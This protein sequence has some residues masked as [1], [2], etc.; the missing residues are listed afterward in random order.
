MIKILK[1]V[2]EMKEYRG[3]LTATTVG[4]VPTMGS[5]HEGHFELIRNSKKNNAVTIVS[6]FVN[7]AQ[8]NNRNDFETYP[9]RLESDIAS[10][11]DLGVDAVITPTEKDVYPKGYNFKLTESIDSVD[12]C[13][14]A[15]PGHFD[16]VL[17]VL[18]KLFNLVKPSDVYMGIK[19]YQQFKLVKNMAEDLFL[20]LTVH[21]VETV[22]EESGLALSSRNINL[23]SEQKKTAEEYANIFAQD[24]P[25]P[26]IK[27]QLEQLNLKIDYLVEKWGRKFVAVFIGNVRLIDNRALPFSDISSSLE[28]DDAST[29]VNAEETRAFNALEIAKIKNNHL[30]D[31]KKILF[32]MSGSIACYKACDVISKLVQQGHQVKVAVTPDVFHF[33]GQGTIEGLIGSSVYVDM[34]QSGEMMSHIHLN[35]WCDITIL[36][37][38]SANTLT[39]I[40]LG[41]SDNLVT[42]LALS[43]D[44][45]KPYLVFP[46]MNTRML[47][48]Q[49]TQTSLEKLKARGQKII[50]GESGSLACGHVG[51][52]RLAEPSVILDII[53]DELRSKPKST[54]QRQ[55]VN[56]SAVERKK[57]LVTAGGTSEAIDPVRIVT[58]TSTGETGLQIC[59]Y[60]LKDYDVYLLASSAMKARI[61]DKELPHVDYFKSYND[62]EEKLE[63]LL[64]SNEFTAVIHLAAVSD[65]S[66]SVIHFSDKSIT[67]PTDEKIPSTEDFTVEF[68][69]NKK[70]ISEIRRH[71]LNKNIKVI[72]FKLLRTDD[73]S[74]IQREIEKI[75]K[76]SDCVVVNSLENIS[77][78]QHVYEIYNDSGMMFHGT[79]K[80]G[81]A[82]DI[83]NILTGEFLL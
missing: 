54:K 18:I 81:M 30:K 47:D 65:Y 23:N 25:L 24:L 7:P 3:Q 17:T 78:T 13:G 35:D 83:S 70:L 50:L 9:D 71:S 19:D 44:R 61:E 1:S 26:E 57:V 58:N 63:T 43:A 75:L 76:D 33:V 51:T 6:I 28:V 48:A 16:G 15:R 59:D 14:S 62:L 32:K 73:E 22:R 67:L 36:C 79:S 12:L 10:L 60:L 8:F 82:Q 4:F 77:D 20:D 68:K 64:A 21:G 34:Y 72:G 37:P 39:K 2:P 40:A 69:K 45:T 27:E 74:K 56:K 42:S 52:G 29:E 55:N 38:A 11:I 5:L 53:N 41:L 49:P 80:K 66:P 46:A 31:S